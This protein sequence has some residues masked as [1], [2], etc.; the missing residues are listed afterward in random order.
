MRTALVPLSTTQSDPRQ[1][2]GVSHKARHECSL[3][4]RYGMSKA[5]K[6]QS[7]LS[8]RSSSKERLLHYASPATYARMMGTRLVRQEC[9]DHLWM[10]MREACLRASE[11]A[12]HTRGCMG[13][14]QHQSG[15]ER[16]AL[17]GAFS[18]AQGKA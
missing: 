18:K 5:I 9:S 6:T 13:N 17:G 3:H 11:L 10:R 16:C 12:R 7:W 4:Q 14:G 15:C 8:K 2:A 1:N